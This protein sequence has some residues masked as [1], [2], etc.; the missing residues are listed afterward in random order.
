MICVLSVVRFAASNLHQSKKMQKKSSFLQ[1]LAIL[2]LAMLGVAFPA[3]ASSAPAQA[4]NAPQTDST[5]T[6]AL[7]GTVKDH[8]GVP[9][10]GAGV[11]A[12]NISTHQM[13]TGDTDGTGSFSFEGLP[14][15]EYQVTASARD[16]L[17]KTERVHVKDHHV[18]AV[19]FKLKVNLGPTGAPK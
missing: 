11:T 15:G 8:H 14:E 13:R 6:G 7:T 5:G 4:T 9:V 17:A 1:I 12:V 2:L 19:H 10:G 18:S 16:L 3:G